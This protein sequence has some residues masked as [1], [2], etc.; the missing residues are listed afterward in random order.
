MFSKKMFIT[1]VLAGVSVAS[2]G[3]VTK[4]DFEKRMASIE[5]RIAKLE[6]KQNIL[7]ERNLRAEGR[8][9]T[10][11][12]N[13]A[14]VRLE[15]EKLKMRGGVGQ[16]APVKVPE[17]KQEK[18]QQLA[19]APQ[20][21]EPPSTLEAQQRQEPPSKIDTKQRQEQLLYHEDYQKEYNEAFQL[22]QLKQLNQAKE[23][24]IEFIKKYPKTPLTDNAYLWLG[25]IYRDMKELAKAEAVWLT[26]VERCQRREMVDCNKMPAVLYQLGLYYEQKGESKRAREMF[27]SIVKEY[28]Q[29]EEA[30]RAR[31]KLSR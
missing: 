23:K 29:S 24:F 14:G 7:E 18:P 22:Y 26:M 6:E 17:P 5:N 19:E 27:E 15:V 31:I 16:E 20:R 2:C 28:P 10:L 21:Q 30:T 12:E 3:A 4:E 1:I 11:S 9:D 8:I 25:V 13:L